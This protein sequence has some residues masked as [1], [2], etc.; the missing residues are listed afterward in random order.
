MDGMGKWKEQ[1]LWQHSYVFLYQ[2]GNVTL[3]GGSNDYIGEYGNFDYEVTFD[4]ATGYIYIAM[5]D[6]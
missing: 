6:I 5:W 3:V 1:F 4:P 2:N